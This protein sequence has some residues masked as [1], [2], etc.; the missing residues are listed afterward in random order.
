[1]FLL[2]LYVVLPLS[3]RSKYQ[4]GFFCVTCVI[5]SKAVGIYMAYIKSRRIQDILKAKIIMSLFL[6]NS[7]GSVTGHCD[8]ASCLSALSVACQYDGSRLMV[9]LWET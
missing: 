6:K 3:F 2:S 1:M 8:S 7:S 5:L 4:F 9:A